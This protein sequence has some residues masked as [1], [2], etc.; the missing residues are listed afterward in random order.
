M[1]RR[2]LN[3]VLSL[4]LA[5]VLCA[6]FAAAA[7]PA[8]ADEVQ[9]RRTSS[10]QTGNYMLVMP[11]I[12]PTGQSQG[13]YSLEAAQSK[14][15]GLTFR[16]FSEAD[17]GAAVWEITKVSDGVCTVRNPGKGDQGY[18]NLSPE[19]LGYG[20]RQE[21]KYQ[22]SG[23]RC[24]FYTVS[25]GQNYYIRF[26]N[27]GETGEPR[28]ASG[29][30]E[31]SH[32]FL[33]YRGMTEEEINEAEPSEVYPE[34][35]PL[36]DGE[37]LLT[38]A[39]LSDL[40]CD[41]G[42]QSS[43]E[44]IRPSVIKTC[45]LIGQ[46]ESADLV[47]VGGD[48]TSDNAKLAQS[49]G[50]S[51]AIF[52]Q[53]I[54]EYNMTVSG[55]TESGRS[56][57]CAG[58]HE[59]QAG[60]V[61]GY[62]SYAAYVDLML[63][64]C[65]DPVSLYRQKDDKTLT[66]QTYPDYVLGMHYIIEDFDFLVLNAPYSKSQ[67]Y[68]SGTYTWLGKELQEIG[69]EKTVFLLTHYPLTDSRGISTP[70]YGTSGDHYKKLTGILKK[71]PNVIYL[72]GH[73]HGDDPS[74][75]EDTVY[76]Q[77]DTF[78]RITSYTSTGKVVN[79]R[80]TAPTSFITA[81]MGSMSYYRYKLNPDWLG[82]EM[83]KIVQALMI[84]VYP[85]RIVFQMKNYGEA[86]VAPHPLSWTVM[87]T[88]VN[89]ANADSVVLPE[90]PDVTQSILVTAEVNSNVLY[91]SS[92]DAANLSFGRSP[93]TLTSY[94]TSLT[95]SPDLLN[96]EM[97]LTFRT[98]AKNASH[99]AALTEK[100]KSV[101]KEFTVYEVSVKNNGAKADLAGTVK[102]TMSI[103]REF[104]DAADQIRYAAYYLDDSGALYMSLAQSDPETGKLTVALPGT[105]I[106]ALSAAANVIDAATGQPI[107]SGG[108]TPDV[109]AGSELPGWAILLLSI[110]GILI[111]GGA[112]TAVW[113]FCFRPKKAKNEAK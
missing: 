106:F 49:G 33:L 86:F 67:M 108:T 38:I 85:D 31:A 8:A 14:N 21:L 77:R 55:A 41:Y 1:K 56:L 101:V 70:S 9:Y 78:E 112:G 15:P 82:A 47:L 110:G 79:D 80:D 62:D 63:D 19:G 109:S 64:N 32:Q 97:N 7:L 36:P 90:P 57:W 34:P 83:P 59:Y 102:L 66:D 23:G 60:A 29:T 30:G 40:H 48:M 22:I 11:S 81:F 26:T 28:F 88:V 20:S 76:I 37:P 17:G 98:L 93:V 104:G 73:N 46:N 65:G 87:R 96:A 68:S 10:L 103:P 5:L 6:G 105:G 95:G 75:E 74:R 12:I 43:P 45:A 3:A 71:Y 24:M 51:P 58:N 52:S 89:R 72:Y 92:K 25:G 107:G 113:F 54:A 91:D 111:L 100:L 4:I 84:Y 39:C 69:A 61:D 53:V 50:W 99:A 13:N 16:P 27:G 44:R 94:G 35:E 2:G 42:L 18:L